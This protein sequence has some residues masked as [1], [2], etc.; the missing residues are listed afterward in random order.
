MRSYVSFDSVGLAAFFLAVLR[1]GAFFAAVFRAAAFL[2]IVIAFALELGLM[3]RFNENARAHFRKHG[4]HLSKRDRPFPPPPDNHEQL[5]GGKGLG[6]REVASPVAMLTAKSRVKQ[7]GLAGWQVP[8]VELA[9]TRDRLGERDRVGEQPSEV[10]LR[11][12][13]DSRINA[14]ARHRRR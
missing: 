14:E 12:I 11:V 1:G 8:E 6:E 7:G 2:A 13:P 3:R 5:S 4:R 10:C 9:V